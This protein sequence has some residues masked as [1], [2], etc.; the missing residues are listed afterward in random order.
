MPISQERMID[1]A[2]QG[3]VVCNQREAI[4]NHLADM[5]RNG[6]PA[7]NSLKDRTE[8][9]NAKEILTTFLQDLMVLY[10]FLS[11]SL[12]SYYAAKRV[13]E[14]EHEHFSKNK[15]KNEKNRIYQRQARYLSESREHIAQAPSYPMPAAQPF[16]A[17]GAGN[18]IRNPLAQSLGFNA[19]GV[20][21][22]LPSLAEL[23]KAD[24]ITL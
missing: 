19:E 23:N 3:T 12:P 14:R 9:P 4:H 11:E 17:E 1:I 21:R 16:S 18:S 2:T 7:M 10:N 5:V 13:I 15:H 6:L 24:D 22:E 20:K 8:D